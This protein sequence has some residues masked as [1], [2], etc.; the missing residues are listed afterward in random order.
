M[1][2]KKWLQRVVVVLSV[3]LMLVSLP[4]L[5]AQ[6]AP[7]PNES[8]DEE[9]CEAHEH[10]VGTEDC[11]T[12]AVALRTEKGRLLEKSPESLLPEAEATD[13]H[14][15]A[16]ASWRTIKYE[17]FE[18]RFPNTRWR[19]ADCNGSAD[20]LYYWNDTRAL[21]HAGSRSAWP[22]ANRLNPEDYFY[23][24]DMCAW[25]IYGPFSLRDASAAQLRFTYWNQSELGYDWFAWLASRDGIHFSGRQVSGNSSGWRTVT[26]DL[27]K[28]PGLGSC[29]D[30]ATVWI[31]FR[32]G[33]DGSIVEDGPFIDDVFIQAF[34]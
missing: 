19:V 12:V 14:N 32:F 20:G 21:S 6:P 30:D 26:L 16:R 25:M 24:N 10:A 17:T 4:A 23:P 18:G 15:A 27:A 33:S 5:G 9:A 3:S 31:A 7:Q 34:R 11:H 2:N 8:L 1:P 22:A 29:L 13:E 28:V